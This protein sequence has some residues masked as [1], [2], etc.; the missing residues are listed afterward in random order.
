L[1]LAGAG[2]TG[3]TAKTIIGRQKKR[4]SN[5]VLGFFIAGYLGVSVFKNKFGKVEY[6]KSKITSKVKA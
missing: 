3:S 1:Y 5:S 4:I 6:P 2:S